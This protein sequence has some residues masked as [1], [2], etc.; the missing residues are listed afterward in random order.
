MEQ[1]IDPDSIAIAEELLK[2][3]NHNQSEDFFTMY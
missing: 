3:C 1:A 2:E